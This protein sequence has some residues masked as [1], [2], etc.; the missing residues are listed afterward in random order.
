M[1]RPSR[2]LSRRKPAFA[3]LERLEARA[4]LAATI[5]SA[6]TFGSTLATEDRITGMAVDTTGNIF[7]T[8]HFEGTMDIDP[9]A[10]TVNLTSNGGSDIFVAAFSATNTLLWAKS[11]GGAEDD[12]GGDLVLTNGGIVITG[13][14]R[15]T[16]DADPSASVYGL[17][18][19]GITDVLISRFNSDGGFAWT[20]SIGGQGTDRGHR[21]KADHNG[22]LFVIGSFN[23]AIDFDPGAGSVTRAPSSP[24]GDL[25]LLKL[26]GSGEFSWVNTYFYSDTMT[27]ENLV[28]DTSGNLYF[29]GTLRG[30]TD[31][32]GTSAGAVTITEPDYVGYIA[33]VTNNGALLLNRRFGHSQ[34]NVADT[35][36]V[37]DLAVDAGGNIIVV[38]N[39]G[40]T[41]DMN[42]STAT[43]LLTEAQSPA[44]FSGYVLKLDASA[45]F[46]W[47]GG[48]VG[49][50][51]SDIWSVA[52]DT[53][54]N[55]YIGG[56]FNN[57]VDFNLKAGTTNRTAPN[58]LNTEF[59]AK[60][61][62]NGNFLWETHASAGTGASYATRLS[63]G[64]NN[65]VIAAGY[66]I[67][68][69][70]FPAG[71]FTPNTQDN[72]IKRIKQTPIV[73][74]VVF[75]PSVTTALAGQTI[76]VSITLSGEFG[77]PT[78]NVFFYDNDT[79]LGL[80]ALN[81]SGQATTTIPN[82][83]VG[84]HN[85]S[86]LYTGDSNFLFSAAGPTPVNV[87][88][89]KA[90][91]GN[92]DSSANGAL[93]GWTADLDAKDTPLI[94]QLWIDNDLRATMTA[95]NVRGDLQTVVGATNHGFIFQVPPL[96]GGVHAVR[97]VTYDPL[98][99][100]STVIASTN[101]TTYS[102]YYDET[103]YLRTYADIAAAVAAGSLGSGWQ[104]YQTAGAKEGRSPSPYFDEMWYRARYPDVGAA[105]AAGGVYS[106]FTHFV[107]NGAHEGRDPSPYFNEMYYRRAYADVAGAVEAETLRSGFQHFMLAG[108]VEGR[109]GTPWFDAGTYRSNYADIHAAINTG[110][111]RSAYDHFATRGVIE[112]RNPGPYYIESNYLAKNA[113]IQAAVSGG[114]L[115]SGIAH[116]VRVGFYEGRLS[117]TPFDATWYRAEY[118][119]VTPMIVDGTVKSAFQHFLLY[120][121]LQGYLPRPA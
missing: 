98:T 87:I 8:G 37:Y 85:V 58:T 39:F 42:P 77:V 45:N 105:V 33:K 110:A 121:R 47:A 26:N 61:D 16:I 65:S 79:N 36:R 56:E 34:G 43:F 97:L 15:S 86:A 12:T 100:G 18:S 1:R 40:G 114:S 19:Q 118:P 89:N 71:T 25:Y 113:D 32:D 92:L 90:P 96:E 30:S 31:I 93:S 119:T 63:T 84:T 7:V 9:G 74:T 4:L 22:N 75:T 17:V 49:N 103:W 94:V 35:I 41:V 76:T 73:P 88:V 48:L 78:G 101:L 14:Y 29:A 83:T 54:G 50:S 99:G 11:F 6:F 21:L 109:S 24:A 51:W 102:L 23:Q 52:T 81:A 53:Y 66:F 116:F 13:M 3:N 70:T 117:Y 46:V 60:Y 104:H 44:A 28:I 80:V 108:L 72:F 57:T 82:L 59:V 20:K 27:I 38:G 115:A 112:K 120:G 67:N 64:P 107:V 62:T 69:I 5:D 111:I 106:G 10:G 55:I 91:I 95:S 68:S 2:H